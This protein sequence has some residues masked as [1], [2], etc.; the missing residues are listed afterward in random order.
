MLLGTYVHI[1]LKS[2]FKKNPFKYVLWELPT[3]VPDHPQYIV[4]IAYLY[5]WGQIILLSNIQQESF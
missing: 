3:F 1:L 4:N 2:I 5:P